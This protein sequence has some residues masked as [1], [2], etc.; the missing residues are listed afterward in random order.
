[1]AL[2]QIHSTREGGVAVVVDGKDITDMVLADPRPSVE[3]EV[4]PAGEIGR[5]IVR[6]TLIG[7]LDIE[8]D[9]EVDRA[10]AR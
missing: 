3:V 9:G 1:M 7:D 6:L 8:V 5:S 10:N 4:A 2:I